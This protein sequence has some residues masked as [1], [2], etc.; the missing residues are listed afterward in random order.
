MISPTNP[1][2]FY[3][4]KE[5]RDAYLDS[6]LEDAYD[7]AFSDDNITPDSGLTKEQEIQIVSDMQSAIQEKPR[8]SDSLAQKDRE[9]IIEGFFIHAPKGD[10]AWEQDIGGDDFAWSCGDPECETGW[11]TTCYLTNMGR[12]NGKRYIEIM[13]MSYGDGD[14][15]PD[16]YWEDGEDYT[17]LTS[18]EADH[19][20]NYFKGWAEYWLDCALTAKDPLNQLIDPS[21]FSFDFCLESAQGN[22]NYM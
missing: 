6:T 1:T 7:E 17:D 12:K 2:E 21:R 15:Q 13:Y 18:F 8:P 22:I 5:S 9:E 16:Q 20:Y 11:H 3:E 14:W 19:L 4:E 10:F